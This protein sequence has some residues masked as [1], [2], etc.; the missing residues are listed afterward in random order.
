LRAFESRQPH[1][2][3]IRSS[4]PLEA[5]L[6]RL[7]IR[8]EDVAV[9]FSPMSE[10]ASFLRRNG[11]TLSSLLDVALPPM[12]RRILPL[13]EELT[14]LA[15]THQLSPLLDGR[16][17]TAWLRMLQRYSPSLRALWT[18]DQWE[19]HVRC[20]RQTVP[21]AAKRLSV[22]Y[23]Q[24]AR[25][26]DFPTL[27]A[28]QNWG[29]PQWRRFFREIGCDPDLA[30]AI[31][32]LVLD[33]DELPSGPRA[34]HVYR[35]LGY[36]CGWGGRPLVSQVF[37]RDIPVL[38]W[39]L[40][41]LAAL[42]CTPEITPGGRVC[43]G[44]PVR[45]FCQ[46]YRKAR[47]KLPDGRPTFVDLFAGAGGLSL[48]M[49]QAGLRLGLAVEKESH[50]ADTLYLNHPEAANG[51][52]LHRD[53]R[54]VL[55]KR[56]LLQRLKGVDVVAGGPPC[57]AWSIVRR[58]SG[59]DTKHPSRHLVR[60]FVRAARVL[61]PKVAIME[62]VPGLRT[63]ENGSALRRTLRAFRRAGF[64]VQFVELNAADYGVPQNRKRV[65][66]FA[67]NRRRLLNADQVLVKLLSEIRRRRRRR[68]RATVQDALS[69]LPKIRAGEGFLVVRR[70]RRG[71]VSGYAHLL[72]GAELLIHNHQARPHNERDLKIFEDL[73]CGEVAWQYEERK[74]GSIPYRLDSFS[75]KYRKLHPGRQ[76]PTI[77][78][79]LR[80]D[81]NSYVHPF[82]ARGI[83]P[84]E[85][86]RLQSFPDDYVFL[87]GFGPSF[88]QIGNAV[89]PLLAESLGR[90]ILEKLA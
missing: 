48:G 15:A 30:G 40:L 51:V 50:A 33:R 82:E 5:F 46:A 44:C 79:H 18:A 37:P 57:Q 31:T 69:G 62:N 21:D 7:R 63:A 24:L 6:T 75:D 66:F 68:P 71:P 53:V 81:A 52:V 76:S 11:G 27:T 72:S 39:R 67:V 43:F 32:S 61:S 56:E 25:R 8:A 10:H 14:I 38:K 34:S 85:A 36:K 49:A 12:I 88:I 90:A 64:A 16:S 35:R 55:G 23:Q 13:I 65:F 80:R 3:L 83:T 59:A 84:R 20:W 29:Q 87:G 77:P 54:T 70:S 2:H 9:G 58:H 47:S 73:R 89:P 28:M 74:P 26:H 60:E 1:A 41:Q 78:S 42:K 4:S 86:A 17:R 45:N 19:R 22:M